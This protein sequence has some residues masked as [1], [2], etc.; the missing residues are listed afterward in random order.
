MD[1]LIAAEMEALADELVRPDVWITMNVV[2][3]RPVMVVHS[4]REVKS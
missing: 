2:R 1:A 4:P 3:G